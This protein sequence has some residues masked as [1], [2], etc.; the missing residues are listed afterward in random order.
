MHRNAEASRIELESASAEVVANVAGRG[1]ELA[2]LAAFLAEARAR[3][4]AL[5]LE[6]QAGIG[7]TTLWR[8]GVELAR[9]ES[10]R[11]LTCRPA[12]SEAQLSFAALGDLLEPLAPGVLEA[13]PLPRRRV[14]ASAL[15]LEGGEGV[16]PDR[17]TI[18]LACLD[19]LRALADSGPLLVAIDDLQWLDA[20]SATVLEFALRRL[21]RESVAILAATRSDPSSRSDRGLRD[22]LPNVRSMEVRPLGLGALH[23]VLRSRLGKSYPRPLLRQVHRASNGNPFYA[24][25]LAA[26]LERR[27]DEI[28]PG[29]PLPLPGTLH[30]LVAEQVSDLPEASKAVL[31]VVAA[32]SEASLAVLEALGL[33]A[34]G[35]DRAVDA[36]VLEVV[37]QRVCFTHPLL[38]SSVY[39]GLG[40]AGRRALHARLAAVM[41]EPEQRARHLALSSTGPDEGVASVLDLGARA[42][43]AKGAQDAAA[44]LYELADRFTVTGSHEESGLRALRAAECHIAAGDP[45]RARVILER[46]VRTLPAGKHRAEALSL[47]SMQ[48]DDIPAAIRLG[49][50]A[51]AEA[52]DTP[53]LKAKTHRN[54]AELQVLSGDLAA[55]SVE[56]T[57]AVAS[58]GEAGD[59]RLQ[60][61]ASA[62]FG[63]V[64]TLRGH[65][66]PPE[67]EHAVE[68]SRTQAWPPGEA[69]P[70]LRLAAL[71]SRVDELERARSLLLEELERATAVGDEWTRVL[72]YYHLAELELRG[73]DWRQASVHAEECKELARQ[74]GTQQERASALHPRARVDAHLGGVES[75]AAAAK[76][77]LGVAEQL[78]DRI[79]TILHR[80]VLG[81]IALSLGDAAS[82]HSWLEPAARLT[83]DMGVGE[84]AFFPGVHDEI[85]AAIA[86]GELEWAEEIV[87]LF[88]EP[89]R[90]LDRA[91][92][93]AIAARGRALLLAARGD[94]RSANTAA[95]TA[96]SEAN[97]VPQPFERARTLL[98]AGTVRRRAKLR[99]ESRAALREALL[100]FEVLGAPLWAA[101]TRAELARLGGRRPAGGELTPTERQ[102][103][104]LVSEGRS[105]KEVAAATFTTVRTVEGHLTK[106]YAK[107][108]VRSRGELA[109]RLAR[110]RPGRRT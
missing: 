89:A 45:R 108:G 90:R 86:V 95:D 84:F 11:T 19:I 68:L 18:G 63:F 107:L 79:F 32:A 25:Q 17:R 60:A 5:V 31:A 96:L 4:A 59:R 29:Q 23:K 87:E 27:G 85:E 30:E 71:L 110:S 62:Y 34:N 61:L 13:L 75:A 26:A 64:E 69:S 15:L 52:G 56:A 2:S 80:G 10:F 83:R 54:L 109:F 7:K 77:G 76:E 73:G 16:S 40:P 42:A 81:F 3:P 37:E 103:A 97:R 39:S 35:I 8:A 82:A 22:A 6:G 57:S 49:K 94:L 51:V 65:G 28:V 21:E 70:A 106:I 99:R 14:L 33:A 48:Q 74:V 104:E 105:N 55:A 91:W 78:G 20:S 9:Q 36:G 38:G 67:A 72:V 66:I 1:R 12:S 24:L 53:P 98:V 101:K 46:L 102:I 41:D 100:Q 47:L 88:E 50:R 92:A 93:L 58:A 44:E 43:A